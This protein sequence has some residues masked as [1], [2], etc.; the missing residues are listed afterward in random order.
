MIITLSTNTIAR[1]VVN[2]VRSSASASAFDTGLILAPCASFT[3]EKRLLTFASAAEAAAGLISAGFTASDEA[4]KAALKYFGA[5]PS[6]AKLLVSCYP[7]AESPAAALTAAL[8]KTSGF[9]GVFPAGVTEKATLLALDEAVRSAEHPM[10]LFLP[11]TGTPA[12]VTASGSLLDALFS[13]SSRRALVTYVAGPSDAA[14]VMGTAMG[15][16]AA[17][18]ASA[19]S[20]CYQTVQG[21][22]PQNL[23]QAEVDAIQALNGNV[24]VTRG[25]THLLLEKGTTASGM[26]YDEMLY[27]DMIAD[28]LQTE[29]VSLLA[30]RG[31]RLPQT[32]DTTAQFINRFSAVLSGFAD[33]GVLATG[34]WRGAA[35]GPL[36]A[37]DVLENGFTLWADSY[38]NQPDADRAAHKAMP[39]QVALLLAG[40]VESIVIAVNVVI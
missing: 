17:H 38:D 9:Y 34:V 2:A 23:T 26:R 32:D 37:G 31:S 20:L 14:A 39:V 18:A 16:Q 33:R 24:Y 30:D 13:L 6:P 1:V 22:Q 11:V 4:Y 25:F 3:E 29:A 10:M 5:S 21:I 36:A 27:L 40:S 15:L 19:F 8:Q 35:A 28:A 12:S 7:S